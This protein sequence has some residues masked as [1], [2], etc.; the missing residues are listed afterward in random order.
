[1][2][3]SLSYTVAPHAQREKRG[4][5][6][7]GHTA[8]RIKRRGRFGSGRVAVREENDQA[9]TPGLGGSFNVSNQRTRRAE[10]RGVLKDRWRKERK[11][12]GEKVREEETAG[13]EEKAKVTQKKR[14]TCEQSRRRRNAARFG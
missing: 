10:Q 14:Q 6:K 4:G 5:C 1:L 2:I 3:A 7:Q 11:A 9:V 8:R 12:S 13:F